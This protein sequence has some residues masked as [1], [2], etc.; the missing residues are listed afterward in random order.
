MP[1]TLYLIIGFYITSYR[2]SSNQFYGPR[3][4]V[5]YSIETY[6]FVI[7]TARIRDYRLWLCGIIHDKT[8]VQLAVLLFRLVI[9]SSKRQVVNSSRIFIFLAKQSKSKSLD[10]EKFFH[11]RVISKNSSQSKCRVSDGLKKVLHHLRE[12]NCDSRF[13]A[14]WCSPLSFD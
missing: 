6:S 1:F 12:I 2:L 8:V 5:G 14:S 9:K 11:R 3:A 7:G 10:S 13:W 4:Q